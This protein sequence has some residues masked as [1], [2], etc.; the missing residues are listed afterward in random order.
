[1]RRIHRGYRLAQA[2]AWARRWSNRLRGK[3]KVICL[4]LNKTG[5]SSLHA[6]F[7][8]LG[9][10]S[11][12]GPYVF[13]E[14]VGLA[15]RENRRLLHYLDEY[16]AFSDI[17]MPHGLSSEPLLDYPNRAEFL[18]RIDREYPGSRFILNSRDRDRWLNS[19]ERHVARNLEDPAY[20]GIWTR[21]EPD[22]WLAEWQQHHEQVRAYFSGRPSDLL[23]MDVTAGDGWNALCPFLDLPVPDQSFPHSNASALPRNGARSP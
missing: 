6:A 5:T 17:F 13:N 3:P 16:D 19:R 4:G 14:K 10:K 9:L 8:L 21:I 23:V 7:Q 2:A 11:L 15:L 20:R 18:A 1:M 22:P 12:H